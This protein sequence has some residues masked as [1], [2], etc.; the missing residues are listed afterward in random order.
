MSG[1]GKPYANIVRQSAYLRAR[2]IPFVPNDIRSRQVLVGSDIYSGGL[3][4]LLGGSFEPHEDNPYEV[5]VREAKDE[6]GK[7][8]EFMLSNPMPL[9][10]YTDV[11][12]GK[13]LDRK[14]DVEHPS[15]PKYAGNPVVFRFLFD[16]VEISGY[17][18]IDNDPSEIC[19]VAWRY[20]RPQRAS[21]K[22]VTNNDLDL[23]N[24]S[25]IRPSTYHGI[26][27]M[28][29]P[30]KSAEWLL[31]EPDFA[32]MHKVMTAQL[33]VPPCLASTWSNHKGGI[34]FDVFGRFGDLMTE[35]DKKYTEHTE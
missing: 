28:K 5:A 10:F 18:P 30:R 35:V 7:H 16:V 34:N 31:F 13:V 21:T 2:R 15:H 25:S 3:V 1:S 19:N 17:D 29:W 20:V 9:M 24:P 8:L 27:T 22:V 26:S 23:S 32:Q 33:N 11:V 14:V 12:S 6:G 4:S